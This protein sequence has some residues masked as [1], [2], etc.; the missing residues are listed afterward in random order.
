MVQ[1][2]LKAFSKKL[3]VFL[4]LV[5][6]FSGCAGNK[7][8]NIANLYTAKG[9]NIVC[10]GNSLTKGE[11]AGLPFVVRLRRTEEG[12]GKDYPSILRR[13]LD[14]PVIN[15]GVNGD[16]T[17]SALRRLEKDVLSKDPRIVIVELGAN[18]YLAWGSQRKG[19]STE[20]SFKNLKYVVDKI[21][22]E[23]AIVIIAAIPFDSEYKRRYKELAKE[24]GALLIPDIMKG[25]LGNPSLMSLDRMHPNDKGYQV[26]AENILEYL[27]PLLQEMRQEGEKR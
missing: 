26:M 4:L 14:L 7:F 13:K 12:E 25:I 20:E 6:L 17:F 27:E 23:G 24:T 5:L 8:D 16:T 1:R 3:L 19:P 15:A 22:K 10:F 9:E 18:D 2:S 21:I 11:G